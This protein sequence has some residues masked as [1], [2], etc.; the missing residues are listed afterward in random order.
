MYIHI[1]IH[2]Y[3]HTHGPRMPVALNRAQR[4]ANKYVASSSEFESRVN[5]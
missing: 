1:H 3:I 5:P 4:V 2:L